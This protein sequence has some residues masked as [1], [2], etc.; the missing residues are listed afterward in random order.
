MLKSGRNNKKLGAKVTA[1]MWKDMP[2]YS[3]SLEERNTC[4]KSCQQWDNCYGDNMP[5]AH[6]FDHTHR[7]FIPMLKAQIKELSVKH[8][9]GFVV[10]LHVLGD[11][12]N[13][14][15]IA[16]WHEMLGDF[17]QLNVFGYTHHPLKSKLGKYVHV[18]NGLYAKR[19]RVRF[20]DDTTT[21][22]SAHVDTDTV[23]HG[24][25]MCP[26]QESKTKSCA[27][28]GFCWSSERPIVF[29]EH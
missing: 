18:L 6:R 23:K 9:N 16:T 7:D 26:E 8:P 25:I 24:G 14:S 28:C 1:K 2:L 10:R 3:L 12:Y 29:V 21:E 19:W 13:K 5:F 17:P 20:S 11:F 15:Y 27:A 4:P 22:F